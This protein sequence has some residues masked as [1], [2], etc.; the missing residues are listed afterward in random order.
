MK[1]ST[2]HKT[3]GYSKWTR[4]T[5][6]SICAILLVCAVWPQGG[7]TPPPPKTIKATLVNHNGRLVPF[8]APKTQSWVGNDGR[9]YRVTVRGSVTGPTTTAPR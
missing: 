7:V 5:S 8:L 2:G 4:A 3:V 9:T 6:L 1:D